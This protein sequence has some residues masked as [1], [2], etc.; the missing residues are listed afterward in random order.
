MTEQ[1][2]RQRAMFIHEQPYFWLFGLY[3]MATGS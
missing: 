3:A 1:Q 2:R